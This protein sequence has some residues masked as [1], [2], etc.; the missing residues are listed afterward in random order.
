MPSTK[1]HQQEIIADSIHVGAVVL[2]LL[3]LP[4]FL[5]VFAADATAGDVLAAIPQ[6]LCFNQNADE[7]D[8]VS[9]LDALHKCHYVKLSLLP[10]RPTVPTNVADVVLVS[11]LIQLVCYCG[12][13]RL[14]LSDY[15]LSSKTPTASS[16]PTWQLCRARARLA[17][18]SQFQTPTSP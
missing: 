8:E 11:A 1:H 9:C 4:S 18:L 10:A 14:Q 12:A 15:W 13:C 6:E 7:A 3:L 17:P 2:L 5:L 16:S